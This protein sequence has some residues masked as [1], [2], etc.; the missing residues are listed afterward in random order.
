MATP[1][2]LPPDPEIQSPAWITQFYH[3]YLWRAGDS[4]P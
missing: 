4:G 2:G 3:K 1:K